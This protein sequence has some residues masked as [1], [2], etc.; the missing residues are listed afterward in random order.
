MKI[1]ATI[2]CLLAVTSSFAQS[3]S[4]RGLVPLRSSRADVEKLLGPPKE[5]RYS[6]P[7][8][9]DGET[10][11][12]FE[13]SNGDCDR[14]WDVPK[15]TVLYITIEYLSELR[16]APEELGINDTDFYLKT[17]DV[18]GPGSYI[19]P[20][21]GRRYYFHELRAPP[22]IKPIVRSTGYGPTRSDNHLRCDGFP[23]YAPEAYYWPS[24]VF[25]FNL[26]G[27]SAF[28]VLLARF[29]EIAFR[30]TSIPEGYHTY[31]VVYFDPKKRLGKYREVLGRIKEHVFGRRK[32]PVDQLT[33]IEGGYREWAEFEVI[34]V[35]KSL[36]PPV[37]TP[38]MASPQFR[39]D[40]GRA[41]TTRQRKATR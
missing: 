36:P 40:A 39:K 37:P 22:G 2:L 26:K 19:N 13:Y 8:Y 28:N 4:W 18:V 41:E 10:F 6:G 21:T 24:D 31:V 25:P 9:E 15:D 38:S 34:Y 20:V 14:G 17:T 5:R 16:Q 3:N 7:G 33:L 11:V 1:A 32:L 23:P 29:D 30:S 12:R 35:H 27:G